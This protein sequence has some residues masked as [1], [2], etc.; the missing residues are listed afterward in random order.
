MQV[1]ETA[2]AG[3]KCIKPD[4]FGDVRGFF[5]EGYSHERYAKE[6]GMTKPVA[7]INFSR[8]TQGVLRGLHYQLEQP[9][10]KLITV[11]KGRVLDVAVDI[12][13][14]S[15]TFGQWVS[16]ELS[17]EN[18]LQLYIPEGFAHGFLVLS[19]EADFF[20]ACTDYYAP[21]FEKGI[22]WADPTLAISWGIVDPTLSPKDKC[23]PNLSQ[24]L[25]KDLPQ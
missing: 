5:L 17:E 15:K 21:K 14:H 24:I 6:V 7:Q 10:A 2:L 12:R 4:R 9:Q 22:H 16:F 20:Y 13:K 1:I 18:G 19:N 23:Y 8:S 25:K 11:L 3:L